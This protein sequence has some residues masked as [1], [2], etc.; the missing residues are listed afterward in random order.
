MGAPVAQLASNSLFSLGLG[1]SE[2]AAG[3]LGVGQST[4][5]VLFGAGD[6]PQ[7]CVLAWEAVHQQRHFPISGSSMMLPLGHHSSWT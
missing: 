1:T 5:L 7:G 4:H 6:Q 2:S 3:I